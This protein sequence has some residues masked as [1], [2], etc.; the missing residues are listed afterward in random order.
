MFFPSPSSLLINTNICS[1][2]VT[3]PFW[4]SSGEQR[5]LHLPESNPSPLLLSLWVFCPDLF[6]IINWQADI[7]S[8]THPH[9]LTVQ[10]DIVRSSLAV[11]EITEIQHV[12]IQISIILL[13]L[14]HIRQFL[15]QSSL[16]YGA[17]L[18]HPSPQKIYIVD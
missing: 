15:Q 2:E 9:L 10:Y 12:L 11:V 1:I 6:Y 5:I 16:N 13:L 3:A 14:D 4:Q 7:R 17:S 8:L 18:I